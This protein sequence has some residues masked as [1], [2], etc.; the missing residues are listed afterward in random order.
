[1]CRCCK[2]NQGWLPGDR[3]AV[4]VPSTVDSCLADA[5]KRLQDRVLTLRARIVWE[6]GFAWSVIEEPGA[7]LL[8]SWLQPSQE[9]SATLDLAA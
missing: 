2:Q 7:L 5:A 4:A 9:G 6:R 3:V 1:M 8:E